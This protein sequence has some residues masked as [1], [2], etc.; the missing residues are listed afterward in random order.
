MV[1][2]DGFIIVPAATA[3]LCRLLPARGRKR[4][5]KRGF[6]ASVIPGLQACPLQDWE[7]AISTPLRSY[8]L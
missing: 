5:R 6:G 1:L 2:P 8:G 7:I 3:G 4:D